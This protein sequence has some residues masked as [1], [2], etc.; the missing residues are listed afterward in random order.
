MQLSDPAMADRAVFCS[1][2]GT[3]GTDWPMKVV[4]NVQ[5]GGLQAGRR[6]SIAGATSTE[7]LWVVVAV[8]T[9][10]REGRVVQILES[11]VTRDRH[12]ASQT[13]Q[14]KP[15]ERVCAREFVR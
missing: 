12:S 15:V 5:H 6:F 1:S 4:C 9:L 13:W 7:E 2:L 8:S 3:T 14:W 10:R 11:E